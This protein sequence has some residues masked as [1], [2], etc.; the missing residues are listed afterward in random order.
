MNLTVVTTRKII[1]IANFVA[2]GMPL[3]HST[4]D[5]KESNK[6]EAYGIALQQQ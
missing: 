3:L 1:V 6:S 5:M 4:T 2:A